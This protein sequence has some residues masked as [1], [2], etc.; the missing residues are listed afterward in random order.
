MMAL[1]KG[2]CPLCGIKRLERRA[3][4]AAETAAI[5]ALRDDVAIGIAGANWHMAG[6]DT[7]RRME[8]WLAALDAIIQKRTNA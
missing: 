5:Q 7:R 4:L 1:V 3:H 8:G 2:K 6:E